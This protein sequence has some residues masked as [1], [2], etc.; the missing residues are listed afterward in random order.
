MALRFAQ[1]AA[2]TGQKR[3]PEQW[4]N[5]DAKDRFNQTDFDGM[6]SWMPGESTLIEIL[7]SRIYFV[8]NGCWY[9]NEHYLLYLL[10]VVG[11]GA[12]MG[13]VLSSLIFCVMAMASDTPVV[14]MYKFSR[15][16]DAEGNY[17]GTSNDPFEAF[18]FVTFLLWIVVS[19]NTMLSYLTGRFGL[20]KKAYDGEFCASFPFYFCNRTSL[21]NNSNGDGTLC[22]AWVAMLLW[23]LAI[24]ASI[25]I[26]AYT[27]IAHTYATRN[28][29]FSYLLL[30][31]AG[32]EV[33]G[34]LADAISL[35]GPTG[36]SAHSHTA[37]WFVSINAVIFVPCLA[38]CVVGVFLMSNPPWA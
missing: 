30:T 15:G 2:A 7:A 14:T 3:P 18:V 4:F 37:A 17:T 19:L 5:R 32:F 21:T 8:L 20:A 10:R 26:T 22:C 11:W 13:L 38:V 24:S 27:A 25:L 31:M 36:I 28:E 9:S 12:R 29:W 34:S 35:G 16:R 1:N 23:W 6:R 33:L